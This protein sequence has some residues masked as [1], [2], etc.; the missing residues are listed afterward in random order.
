MI[1]V[2][3]CALAEVVGMLTISDLD[4]QLEWLMALEQPLFALP[5]AGW[6]VVAA[7]YNVVMI[8]VL[9][10]VLIYPREVP[11]RQ[12]ALWLTL[13]VIMGHQ[14]SQPVL[15]VWKNLLASV[16]LLV[17]FCLL[18]YVLWRSLR[19]LDVLGSR[20]FLLYLMWLLY[21]IPWFFGLWWL[22]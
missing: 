19:K 5:L 2:G 4:A 21:D 13:G 3:I 9:Y 8:T 6:Y 17:P 20:V 22:N 16:L 7:I 11:G 18:A 14:V 12:A 15:F 10:R 1:A